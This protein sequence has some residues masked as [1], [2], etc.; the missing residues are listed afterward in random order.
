MLLSVCVCGVG[1]CA[2]VGVG[3]VCVVCVWCACGVCVCVCVCVCVWC[4]SDKKIGI[5]IKWAQP[6]SRLGGTQARFKT[7]LELR[8][9]PPVVA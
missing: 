7:M 4:V 2:C 5:K 9:G 3:V 1:V 6:K 8:L